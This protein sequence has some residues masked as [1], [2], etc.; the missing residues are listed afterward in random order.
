MSAAVVAGKLVLTANAVGTA[1]VTVTATDADK[2]SATQTATITVKEAGTPE[3]P[4][5]ET[6]ETET[7]ETETPE[8]A[9]ELTAKG[10]IAAMTLATADSPK[11]VDVAGYFTGGT[12][13]VTYSATSSVET[14]ATVAISGSSS[15]LTIT[16]VADGLTTVTV[17]ASDENAATA[18]QTFNVTITSGK[19]PSAP[20][21]TVTIEGKGKTEEVAVPKTQKL[22]SENIRIVSVSEK[23]GAAGTWILT[24]VTKGTATVNRVNLVSGV[25]EGTIAVTVNNT[26]PHTTAERP[27][28]R[29]A[30]VER[31]PEQQPLAFRE[32]AEDTVDGRDR[33]FFSVDL[34]LSQYFDDVDGN[35][36]RYVVRPSSPYVLYKGMAATG[37]QPGDRVFL[38]VL[39]KEI[40]G[41]FLVT[42][43]AVDKDKEASPSVT[44]TV[45]SP[46]R[47]LPD[48][49]DITQFENG[50]FKPVEIY[51][52]QD[53]GHTLFFTDV[54][55]APG[56][57]DL[58]T[59]LEFAADH[60]E[61]QGKKTTLDWGIDTDAGERA[62]THRDTGADISPVIDPD[63]PIP[64][65][66][67]A[68]TLR[69]FYTVE[70][71]GAVATTGKKKL[72]LGAEG[73]TG[74]L[75]DAELTKLPI[76]VVRDGPRER[77]SQDH[78]LGADRP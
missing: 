66:D 23:V 32:D 73:T 31:T 59:G 8:T 54:L 71:S 58:S 30:M 69:H 3:T 52:R 2:L 56:E 39:K 51:D 74:D 6:P 53:I 68:T 12:G 50:D 24:G 17:T 29:Y 5:T 62:F 21:T 14:V 1:T 13:D 16:A 64:P 63:P 4:E 36:D 44:F 76:K 77:D 75:T 38:D 28:E 26:A 15:S 47:V 72:V 18:S 35:I 55:L 45:Q 7:P 34:E 49:Y 57:P 42:A 60:L 78:L 70:A 41:S 67:P 48:S 33:A 20:T 40:G 61:K 11:V 27:D 9:T 65:T 25:V 37:G 10:R 46:D 22:E 43:Y 19:T